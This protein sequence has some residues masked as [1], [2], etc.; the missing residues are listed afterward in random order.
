M[1]K[2]EI[3]SWEELMAAEI[4]EW[5]AAADDDDLLLSDDSD[6]FE[7]LCCGDRGHEDHRWELDPASAEDFTDRNRTVRIGPSLRWRHFGH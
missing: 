1:R 3:E 7:E 5:D 4:E 6:C 2:T